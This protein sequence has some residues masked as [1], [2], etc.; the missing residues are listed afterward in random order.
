MSCDTCTRLHTHMNEA[1]VCSNVMLQGSGTENVV[2][3]MK[4]SKVE[5]RMCSNVLTPSQSYNM[6]Q[7]QSIH[8][9]SSQ[10]CGV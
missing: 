5:T 10:E 3:D 6:S 9:L 2:R 1:C 7:T 8:K 4:P